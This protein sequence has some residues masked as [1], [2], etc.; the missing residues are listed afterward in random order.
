MDNAHL[1]AILR[2]AGASEAKDG[3]FSELP[4]GRSA[5]FYAAHNGVALTIARV[6]AVQSAEPFVYLRTS[7]NETFVVA[8]S[9]LFAGAVEGIAGPSRKAGFV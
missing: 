2:T 5:S 9:D 8:T 1:A 6:V 7:K 3:G 4:E